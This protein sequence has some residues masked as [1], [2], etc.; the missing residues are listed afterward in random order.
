MM[1]RDEFFYVLAIFLI[2]SCVCAVFEIIE[3]NNLD[4]PQNVTEVIP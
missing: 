1:L 4:T 3:L 2:F